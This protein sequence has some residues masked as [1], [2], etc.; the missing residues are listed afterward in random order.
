MASCSGQLPGPPDSLVCLFTFS[1]VTHGEFPSGLSD[2]PAQASKGGILQRVYYSY[3]ITTI[4]AIP[5]TSALTRQIYPGK[6]AIEMPFES[7]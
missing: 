5:Q 2:Q 4:N 1:A 6:R 7:L 3:Q